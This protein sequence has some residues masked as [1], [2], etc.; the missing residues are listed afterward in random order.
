MTEGHYIPNVTTNIKK[1]DFISDSKSK[2]FIKSKDIV[3]YL[4]ANKE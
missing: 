4:L 1:K 3:E 2:I